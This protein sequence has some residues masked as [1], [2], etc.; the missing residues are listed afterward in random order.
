[1]KAE[2]S[3]TARPSRVHSAK[4]CAGARSDDLANYLATFLPDPTQVA[5]AA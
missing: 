3:S 4:S 2:H 5:E 1:M